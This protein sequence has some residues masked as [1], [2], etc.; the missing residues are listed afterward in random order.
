[1]DFAVPAGRRVKIKESEDINKYLDLAREHVGD[2]NTNC[3][4]RTW[5]GPLGFRKRV[6]ELKIRGR[7]KT[8]L[9]YWDWPEY[10]EVSWRPENTYCHSDSSDL[11]PPCLTLSI[12]R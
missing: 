12:I 2:S 1:M 8:I 10:W 6:E 5:I 9:Y 7:I 11:M 3:D 4:W